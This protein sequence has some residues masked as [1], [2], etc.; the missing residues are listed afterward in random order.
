MGVIFDVFWCL[1]IMNSVLRVNLIRFI[2]LF[3]NIYILTGFCIVYLCAISPYTT[4][5][6]V[7]L[8]PSDC[9]DTAP[10]HK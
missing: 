1:Y 3:Y 9:T 4:G 10:T 6:K 8:N 7:I 5:L 2:H